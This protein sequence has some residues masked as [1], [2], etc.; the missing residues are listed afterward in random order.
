MI[1]RK[2]FVAADVSPLTLPAEKMEPAH[3]GCYGWKGV[4][5]C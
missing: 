4:T 2:L 1:Y 5:P 3:V